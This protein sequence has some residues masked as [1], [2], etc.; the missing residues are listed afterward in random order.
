MSHSILIAHGIW[1]SAFMQR[2]Y[3]SQLWHYRPS[4]WS[5]LWGVSAV[6]QLSTAPV[7]ASIDLREARKFAQLADQWWDASGPF[8]PLHRLN[9]TRCKFIRDVACEALGLDARPAEVFR[10]LNVLD[11]GCGGGILSESMA[12]MGAQVHGIDITD[13]NI[14]VAQLHAASDPLIRERTK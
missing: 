3:T 1:D 5:A 14:K 10:G 6:R 8:A 13:D 4:N 9:P 12:R 11:V 7:G 2:L